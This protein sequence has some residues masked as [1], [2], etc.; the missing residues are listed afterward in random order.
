MR[1]KEYF[2]SV[3]GG[4]EI[5]KNHQQ[6]T[7]RLGK[8]QM[9]REESGTCENKAEPGKAGWTPFLSLTATEP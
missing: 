6:K 9:K 7:G 2:V 8:S 1:S 3:P 4:S 5:T